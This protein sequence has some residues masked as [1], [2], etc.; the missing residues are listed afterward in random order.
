MESVFAMS[1]RDWIP[2]G[3]TRPAWLRQSWGM[4]CFYQETAPHNFVLLRSDVQLLFK[5][6]N[7]GYGAR[8]RL[9]KRLELNIST[10]VVHSTFEEAET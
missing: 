6:P 1:A 8:S 2:D 10:D 9:M 4:D 3:Q 7:I 5:N